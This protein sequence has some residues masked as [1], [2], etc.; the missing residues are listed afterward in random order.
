MLNILVVFDAWAG[1]MGAAE[2]KK[3]QSDDADTEA[4]PAG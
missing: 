2:S 3:K 1:P 4:A